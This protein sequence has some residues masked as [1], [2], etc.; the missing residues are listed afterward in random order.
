MQD[1]PFS[2][3][4]PADAVSSSDAFG[5]VNNNVPVT[6]DM[7]ITL[8]FT[9]SPGDTATI[10]SDFEITPEPGTLAMIALGGIVLGLRRRRG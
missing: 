3:S 10:I 1:S 4:T 8:N 7:G 6:S 9:L 5:W 2:L